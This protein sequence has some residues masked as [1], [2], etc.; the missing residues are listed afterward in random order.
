MERSVIMQAVT[1]LE[2]RASGCRSNPGKVEGYIKAEYVLTGSEALEKADSLQKTVADVNTEGLK[3]RTSRALT[4][5]C[6]IL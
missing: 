3:V 4:A 5:K 6:W 1:C 2:K